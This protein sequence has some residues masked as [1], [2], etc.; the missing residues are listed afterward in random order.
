MN[1]LKGLFNKAIELA[2]QRDLIGAEQILNQIL[3]SQP[4]EPNAL[5]M[6]G[7]MKLA[8]KDFVL[9]AD[10]LQKA[11]QAAPDFAT[12]QIELSQALHLSGDTIEA[13]TSMRA[14]LDSNPGNQLVWQALANLLFELGDLKQGN[15]AAQRS[16]ELDAFYEQTLS[17]IHI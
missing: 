16:D 2:G 17:L 15:V 4:D 10:Y 5:R 12:A 7:S 8:D 14:F 1:E 11:L 13:L 9:A 3:S 6:L